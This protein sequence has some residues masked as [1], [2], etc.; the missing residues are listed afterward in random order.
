[1]TGGGRRGRAARGE[2]YKICFYFHTYMIAS[3]TKSILY[4]KIGFVRSNNFL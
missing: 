1:M 2:S 4:S 3:D